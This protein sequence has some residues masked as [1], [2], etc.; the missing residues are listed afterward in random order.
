MS[1]L[2]QN[3]R[4]IDPS[5]GL[6]RPGSLLIESSRIAAY[7][8]EPEEG[9]EVIDCTGL[10]IAPG[11]IDIHVQLGEPGCEEDETIETGTAAALAG[12]FT[13]VA[14][15]ADT[16]P[17]IDTPAGVQY[18]LQKAAR[19]A[20]CHVLVIA[21]VSKNREGK[22][23][24]EIGS[25][26]EAG[27]I[28]FSDAS[29][30]IH[31]PD[32][33]RR[34][35]EYCQMFNRPVMNHPESIDLTHDGIMHEGLTSMILGLAGLPAEAEDVMTSRD[36]RLAE[37][38]GGRLHLM[39]ISSGG[40][41]E[42]IRRVKSR[43]QAVTAAVTPHHLT[44]TDDL[45]RSFD[46]A[47]KLN[48]PLRSAE[49][50]EACVAGLQDGTLDCIASGHSP[51]AVEKKM[52]ELDRAP[53]GAVGLETTLGVVVTKLIE[54][55]LLDWPTALAKLTSGPA[56]VLGL[57]KGTLRLGAEAD[58]TVIDP[59]ARWV[60]EPSRFYSKSGNTPFA[61][62]ELRGKAI[63]TIVSG[64]IRTPRIAPRGETIGA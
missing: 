64:Q 13:T 39:N 12:G 58:V 44:L 35:L 60:V 9:D 28:G 16:D 29:S 31:N 23:L 8:V 54:P 20:H 10:I 17:P 11:L 24:A 18:V 7:D 34:A 52:Q 3:G 51:R 36:L 2:L 47:Y 49:H 4:L 6:D 26:V 61:G 19:A 43:G 50:V 45:L 38:T 62:W 57:D 37:A 56:R 32:L 48:P 22:E 14:C 1:I 33:L 59:A 27:A 15:I 30:P 5:Q 55:G 63:Y 40:S 41:V 42:L 25:L 46:S 21:S 53:F